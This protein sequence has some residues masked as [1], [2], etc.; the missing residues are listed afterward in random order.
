MVEEIVKNIYRIPVPLPRNP[1]RELNAYLIRGTERS[2]LID[3]GFRLPPCREAL[4]AGLEETGVDRTRLDVL[5]T[6]IHTDHTGLS[7]EFVGPGGR[8]YIGE[9]DFPLTRQVQ[10]DHFWAVMDRRFDREGFPREEARVVIGTN[11][12]RNLGP[13]LDLPCYTP[14]KDGQRLSVG[15]YTLEV[16][17]VP[18]HT[19]GQICLWLERE[20]I[21]FTADHVLFDITPNIAMWPNMDNALGHYL[22][23]LDRV[24]AY[25]VE[26]A[27]PGHRHTADFFSR[28]E[29]LKA[30]HGRRVAE[31][32]RIV[33]E[34][35]GRTAYEIAARM[36]WDIR[37]RSWAD[38][39][40]NQKWFAVG[41]ALA[42]LEL[43]LTQNKV[44]R[45]VGE[46]GL[47][48]YKIV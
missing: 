37:A 41:E 7:V 20:R 23:S 16:V 24:A 38:F 11:P 5:V 2:L 40:L 44:R 30:H 3:T 45:L 21:L 8:I 36:T 1:L 43:L 35:P 28:V 34:E 25:P 32:L 6:H 14:L 17:A 29:E 22:S 12:A 48:R 13:P 33:R 46:N 39:P 10:E 19:P 27:L 42:H 15:D 47:A 31:T 4:A 26:L 18:G 9:G